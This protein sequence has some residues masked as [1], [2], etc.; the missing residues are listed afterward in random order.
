MSTQTALSTL[1]MND[2]S[3]RSPDNAWIAEYNPAAASIEKMSQIRPLSEHDLALLR[4][5]PIADQT[6]I[7]FS[8]GASW[9]TIEGQCACCKG[10]ISSQH[11]FGQITRP[12]EKVFVMDAMGVCMD[13]HVATPFHYRFHDDKRVSGLFNGAWRTWHAKKSIGQRLKQIFAP[14]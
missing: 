7:E 13:C 12:T 9:K 4:C 14:V 8:N 2:I 10:K 3:V 1:E 6:P 11:M 5:A